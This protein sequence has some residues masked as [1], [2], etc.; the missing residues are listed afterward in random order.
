M[1]RA[2]PKLSRGASHGEGDKTTAGEGGLQ[3]S[4]TRV[5]S[6]KE[7]G[8]TGPPGCL[9]RALAF[10]VHGAQPSAGGSEQGPSCRAEDGLWRCRRAAGRPGQGLLH[11]RGGA[12]GH[13]GR[14]RRAGG[15][16]W[17]PGLLEKEL[18]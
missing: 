14:A 8:R 7:A 5:E 6:S 1:A 16:W 11:R 18:F 15:R 9:V 10:T 2:R 3:G 17:I 12:G 13:G 4:S